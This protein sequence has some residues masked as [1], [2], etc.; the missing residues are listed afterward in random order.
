MDQKELTQYAKGLLD[1]L[2]SMEMLAEAD[3][4]M[5]NRIFY[6]NPAAEEAFAA[7]AQELRGL[8]PHNSDLTKILGRTIHQ[9]HKDPERIRQILRGLQEGK[10]VYKVGLQLGSARFFLTFSAF[11]DETGKVLAF[12]ASWQDQSQAAQFQSQLQEVLGESIHN[13]QE[14]ARISES[15]TQAMGSMSK[16]LAVLGKQV[17]EHQQISTSMEKQVA[18]VGKV[19]Q[20]IREIAYQTNLLALNAAIEA[21]RAGEHGRG[22]AVV[23]DE[24]RNLSRRVQEATEEVQRNVSDITESAQK[25][26]NADQKSMAQSRD[27]SSVAQRLQGEIAKVG[28]LSSI[29]QVTIA[30]VTHLQTAQRL[31]DAVA[32]DRTTLKDFPDQHHCFLGQWIEGTG[33]Q[34]LRSHPDFLALRQKHEQ[35]HDLGQQI[36]TAIGNHDHDTARGL[37]ESLFTARDEILHHLEALQQTLQGTHDN[38]I[39]GMTVISAHK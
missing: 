23:A 1:P 6:L 29:N 21:A 10:A 28:S 22:F 17:E 14:F 19:A 39:M 8:L 7:H 13:A 5:E 11:R 37:L 33:A 27:A 16:N 31:Q 36:L 24:V 3:D 20:S 18:G 15:G 38:N 12:H 2:L 26:Q 30:K 35:F 32:Q 25:M 34:Y 9:F 4:A